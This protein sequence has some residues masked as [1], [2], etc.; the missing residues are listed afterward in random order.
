MRVGYLPAVRSLVLIVLAACGVSSTRTKHDAAVDAAPRRDALVFPDAPLDAYVRRACDAPP[1]FAD[2]LVPTR[3]LHVAAGAIN[4]DGSATAPFGSIAA[5]AAVATPGTFIQLAPGIHATNQFIPDLRG[6]ATAPIWIG[7]VF[8]TRP[9]IRGGAEALH[10]TRPAYVVIQHLELADHE[11]NGINIDDGVSYGGDAHHVAIVDVQVR[12]LWASGQ[13]T[14]V[15]AAGVSDLAIYDSGFERCAVS[16]DLIGSHRAVVARNVIDD[17]MVFGVVARGGSTDVDVRQNRLLG[18]GIS[19]VVLGGSVPLAQFRPPVSATSPNAE[20]R[21]VRVFNNFVGGATEI[22]F[23]FASCSDCLVAHNL[24]YGAPRSLLQIVQ[25]TAT[26]NGY[27]F[28]PTQNGRVINN[29]FV[30]TSLVNAHVVSGPGTAPT[31]FTFSNNLWFST[32]ATGSSTPV[33]PVA[34]TGSVIGM[35]TGYTFDI[36][37]P[38]CVGP[39]QGAAAPLP[40][41]DGTFEGHCRSDGDAPTIG[42]QVHLPSDC[43]I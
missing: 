10:L 24:T 41:I 42:P 4:G 39:E 26:Q 36:T 6:T 12:D 3:V 31:T 1:T 30:W 13:G 28:E 9:V 17:I 22:P 19:G 18:G 25:G 11:A 32:Q 16:V 15:R 38:Y 8:G 27:E 20:A 14:C 2:G 23:S 35:G 7:G 43:L 29:S 37:F 34:E 5:A 21:R 33:L 40:E